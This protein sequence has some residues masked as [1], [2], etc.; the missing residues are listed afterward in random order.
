MNLRQLEK[1]SEPISRMQGL[2]G[3][4]AFAVSAVI[5]Y[6]LGFNLMPGGFLGVDLFF[7]L[8]G[9]LITGILLRQSEEHGYIDLAAFWIRR[10][11]RLLPA[12]FLMLACVLIWLSIFA[13]DRISPIRAEIP[14]AMFYYSNWYLILHNVSYFEQFGPPSPFGHLWSLAIEEQ[15]YLIWPILL[16]IML[17]FLK[18]GRIII[19]TAAAIIASAAAMM[20][21][22]VPG[23]DPSRVYYGTDTR[24]FAILLGALAAM[25]LSGKSFPTT[26]SLKG[27]L[28]LESAGLAGLSVVVL[29][30]LNINQ[31]HSFTYQGG[32]LLFS[33]A[34][35]CLVAV[36]AHPASY[37]GKILGTTPLK[38]IGE[39]SYGIYLWHFPVILLSSPLINTAGPNIPLSLVQI[40]ITVTLA[41]LSRYL[42]EEPIRYGVKRISAASP[43]KGERAYRRRAGVSFRLPA[44]ILAVLLLVFISVEKSDQPFAVDH[45]EQ[46]VPAY[47]DGNQDMN[48]DQDQAQAT[49][50]P[51]A[52]PEGGEPVSATSAAEEE[53]IVTGDEVTVIGDSLMVGVKPYLE[54][55]LPG[56]TVDAKVGRQLKQGSEVIASLENSGLLKNIVVIELGTNGPFTE[57]Q[58]TSLLNSLRNADKIVFI[59]SRVPKPWESTVNST[60]SSVLKSYP[61]ASL[62]DWYSESRGHDEYFYDDGVHLRPVGAGIYSNLIIDAL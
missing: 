42:V 1:I 41:A 52:P 62:I 28:L 4:R 40:C 55:L 12:L 30:M 11:K 26:L 22:Y 56:I 31:Y 51:P 27:R 24:V 8:S 9:F 39:C 38:W 47:Q 3:L 60:L 15:F 29:M 20:L 6:H 57:S 46:A 17:R 49:A 37:L 23:S 50:A 7:V 5:A 34:A 14:A 33:V 53:N 61:K 35:A 32:L 18:K 10:A 48:K 45:L 59:N 54:K 21:I 16:G 44:M 25:L 43:A 36:I 58:L 2:D 19:I 13:P